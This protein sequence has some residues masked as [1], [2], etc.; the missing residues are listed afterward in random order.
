MSCQCLC[1]EVPMATAFRMW[2]LFSCCI[3][4][5]TFV[6][7]QIDVSE[8]NEEMDRLYELDGKVR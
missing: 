3:Y 2:G 1:E 7:L 5:L 6:L 4:H 8:Q